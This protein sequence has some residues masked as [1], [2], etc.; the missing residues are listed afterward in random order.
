MFAT[1]V[2]SSPENILTADK[3]FVTMS[4]INIFNVLLNI[5]PFAVFYVGQVSRFSEPENLRMY[6]DVIEAS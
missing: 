5:L 1:Y 2:L 4:Y 6:S 3:S